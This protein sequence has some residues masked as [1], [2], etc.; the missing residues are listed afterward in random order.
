[1]SD[2]QR[3]LAIIELDQD[4]TQVL[5]RAAQLSRWSGAPLLVLHVLDYQAGFECDQAPV[6]TRQQVET[7]LQEAARAKIG[8]T[9]ARL[10]VTQAHVL[11]LRGRPQEVAPATA[12]EWQADLIVCSKS[13]RYGLDHARP[14]FGRAC[15]YTGEL[16][17]VRAERCGW[18]GRLRAWL[19]PL[20]HSRAQ[21]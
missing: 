10:G 16:L 15:A 9:L 18:G 5:R 2:Y 1:M 14:A 13:A 12:R 8:A 4:D 3:I 19:Q 6:L 11:V 7:S 17:S 20:L 21:P